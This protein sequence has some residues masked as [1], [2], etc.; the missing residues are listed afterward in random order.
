VEDANQAVAG[1]IIGR[2][3]ERVN[4]VLVSG[5]LTE[6]DAQT[7]GITFLDSAE[8]AISDAVT[9]LPEEERAGSVAVIP[10]AGIILPLVSTARH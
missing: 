3:K 4:L 7:M 8:E 10:Q 6:T 5:G 9:R 1:V 2:L